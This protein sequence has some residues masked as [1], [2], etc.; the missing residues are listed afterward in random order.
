MLVAVTSHLP[1]KFFWLIRL[2]PSLFAQL[3]YSPFAKT[4]FKITPKPTWVL[5]EECVDNRFCVSA[6]VG[7]GR[8]L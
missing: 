3:K 2:I 1:E 7:E 8:V 6:D 5:R 4:W